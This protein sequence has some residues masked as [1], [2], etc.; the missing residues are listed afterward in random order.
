MQERDWFPCDINTIPAQAAQD[1]HEH[2]Q[3]GS[4]EDYEVN[5][6]TQDVVNFFEDFSSEVCVCGHR[7]S[8]LD[9]GFWFRSGS[10]D[11]GRGDGWSGSGGGGGGGRYCE[12]ENGKE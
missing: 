9:C 5:M 12:E 1:N 3:K 4:A 11:S 6:P 2:D 8:S 7:L 10:G